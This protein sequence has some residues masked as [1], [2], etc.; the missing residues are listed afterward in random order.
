[1]ERE[2]A[3][4]HYVCIKSSLKSVNIFITDLDHKL[5][6]AGIQESYIIYIKLCVTEAL[7]NAIIWGSKNDSSK[8]I[9]LRYQFCTEYFVI[10]IEDEGPGFDWS[11]VDNPLD[12]SNI[13]RESGRGLLL[14][15]SFMDK[16]TF[17]NKGNRVT[18]LKYFKKSIEVFNSNSLDLFDIC[19]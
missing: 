6:Q 17:N 7:A 10:S 11:R 18:M 13:M 3:S 8:V 14:M 1:M 16:V 9:C 12:S 2:E 19:F 15:K 5:R 4:N